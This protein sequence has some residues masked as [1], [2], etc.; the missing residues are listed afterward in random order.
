MKRRGGSAVSSRR[1]PVWFGSALIVL[2]CLSRE[3]NGVPCVNEEIKENLAIQVGECNS[4]G[5]HSLQTVIRPGNY[6]CRAYS[7]VQLKIPETAGPGSCAKPCDAGYKLGLVPSG[8]HGLPDKL[9]CIECPRNT[10]SVGGGDLVHH[11]GRLEKGEEGEVF[12]DPVLLAP[13]FS[14]VCWGFNDSHFQ[15]TRDTTSSWQ[16]GYKC[17]PWLPTEDGAY[18][19]SGNSREARRV[20]SEMSLR[21]RFVTA[22]KMWFKFRVSADV[23][24]QA[25]EECPWL[26]GHTGEHGVFKCVDGTYGN[27]SYFCN[28]HGGRAQCPSNFPIMC[29]QPGLCAGNEAYCCSID[30]SNFGGPRLC[31]DTGGLQVLV[32]NDTR[33]RK[34]AEQPLQDPPFANQYYSTSQLEWKWVQLHFEPGWKEVRFRYVRQ[35][36]VAGEDKAYI[37]EVGWFGTALADTECRDCPA[38]KQSGKGSDRCNTCEENTAWDSR[39]GVCK[40]CGANE[41][42]LAGATKCTERPTCTRQ[43][44][45][46]RFS[47]CRKKG[48][49]HVRDMHFEWL[50]PKVCMGGASLPTAENDVECESCGPGRVRKGNECVYCPV[51]K[52]SGEEEEECKSCPA[53]SEAPLLRVYEVWDEWPRGMTTGCIG[54]CGTEG[55]RL[56]EGAIDSG[57]HHMAPAYSWV[58]LNINLTRPGMVEFTYDLSCHKDF[59]SFAMVVNGENYNTEAKCSH[60]VDKRVDGTQ[61]IHLLEGQHSLRWSYVRAVNPDDDDDDDRRRDGERPTP[62]PPGQHPAP[63]PRPHPAPG[64]QPHPGAGAGARPHGPGQGGKGRGQ[65]FEGVAKISRIAIY[66]VDVGGAEECS[67]CKA[68]HFSIGP[69]KACEPCPVG[70]FS[71]VTDDKK[72]GPTNCTPCP[73]DTFAPVRGSP[74]CR[75]CG[76]NSKAP[77]GSAQCT[78]EFTMPAGQGHQEGETYDMSRVPSVIGPIMLPASEFA[79]PAEP[80]AD[81]E[82]EDEDEDEE[83]PPEERGLYLSLNEVLVAKVSGRVA[84]EAAHPV[85]CIGTY[86]CVAPVAEGAKAPVQPAS[87]Y[88]V[89]PEYALESVHG[90]SLSVGATRGFQD[91]P[92]WLSEYKA[93]SSFDSSGVLWRAGGGV[94]VVFSDGGPCKGS[95]KWTTHLHMVCD[96]TQEDSDPTYLSMCGDKECSEVDGECTRHILWE[97]KYGCP[98]CSLSSFVEL[99]T[100]CSRGFRNVSFEYAQ[101]CFGGMALPGDQTRVRCTVN[102]NNMF[103]TADK[104][105]MGFM[106]LMAVIV[107]GILAERALLYKRLYSQYRNMELNGGPSRAQAPADDGL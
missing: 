17:E 94:T 88:A 60:S 73:V 79:V 15:E 76:A 16:L 6:S 104:V 78:S 8:G 26:K 33:I 106:G 3:A 90:K 103:T 4:Y 65:F 38:G 24:P 39:H 102:L 31:P 99:G 46:K 80:E 95:T 67:K 62:T 30:C 48:N 81:D 1:S 77:K 98:V 36:A 93:L 32:C 100:A 85:Q 72:P 68:G 97:T 47:D 69:T 10:F 71:E 87:S 53:G 58:Q 43:D 45:V 19:T 29:A 64:P 82:D 22:G 23:S 25:V 86:A 54:Q 74:T 14:S 41:Y 63:E 55:W 51:G 13:S 50:E 101:E 44:W 37:Q 70:H 5:E 21:L 35:G 9:E 7:G 2:I 83:E 57:V 59:S 27:N 96:K 52:F 92:D 20:W 75:P 105:A 91:L 84:S 61:Q 56:H 89:P 18:I 12:A 28:D 42:A 11:W 66:N 34:C 40:T 107:I 49:K